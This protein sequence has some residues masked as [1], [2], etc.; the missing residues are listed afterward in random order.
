LSTNRDR[1]LD[2]A[3]AAA[4]DFK[5]RFAMPD[6][7]QRRQIWEK[8]FPPETPTNELDFDALAAYEFSGGTIQRRLECADTKNPIRICH[9]NIPARRLLI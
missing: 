3:F 9:A 8:S 2:S 4:L 5:V 7:S 6:A 1:D